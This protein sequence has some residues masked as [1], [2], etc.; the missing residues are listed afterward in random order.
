MASVVLSPSLEIS[1]HSPSISVNPIPVSTD[2]RSRDKAPS[3]HDCILVY[4]LRV[5]SNRSKSKHDKSNRTLT[6]LFTFWNSTFVRHS[7]DGRPWITTQITWEC[8]LIH[9]SIHLEIPLW[10]LKSSV[11]RRKIDDIVVGLASG[12]RRPLHVRLTLPDALNSL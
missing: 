2:F 11:I 4:G 3:C 1:F 10:N 8:D 7:V 5:T 9:F 12:F 6:G